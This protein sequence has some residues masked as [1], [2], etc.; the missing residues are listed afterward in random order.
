[1]TAQIA[2][3]L[4]TAHKLKAKYSSS[5]PSCTEHGEEDKQDFAQKPCSGGSTWHAGAALTLPDFYRDFEELA[6][7][8]A[9]SMAIFQ[10]DFLP[11]CACAAHP[12][13]ERPSKFKEP[14]ETGAVSWE[15]SA[16]E[17]P[18]IPTRINSS[19]SVRSSRKAPSR[20]SSSSTVRSSRE[21]TLAD[22]ETGFDELAETGALSWEIFVTDFLPDSPSAYSEKSDLVSSLLSPGAKKQA[23]EL[24][25]AAVAAADKK[26]QEEATKSKPQATKSKVDAQTFPTIS[27]DAGSDSE[28][29]V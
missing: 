20:Y 21:A 5:P 15:H 22:G 25:P 14:A 10:S 16:P 12:L 7:T 28:D 17:R 19:S 4:S 26:S 3:R 13:G 27:T 9:V 24:Q 1:M 29:Y 18:K 11:E 2:K 8:G 23:K 6:A